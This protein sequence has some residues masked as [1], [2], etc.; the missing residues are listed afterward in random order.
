M[1]E[2]TCVLNGAY[3]VGEAEHANNCL[4]FEV[5]NAEGADDAAKYGC[6]ECKADHYFDNEARDLDNYLCV[7]DGSFYNNDLDTI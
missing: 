2:K 1:F 6:K 3:K 5:I 7:P 4:Y